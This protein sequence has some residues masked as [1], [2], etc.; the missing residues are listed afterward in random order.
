[1]T[2]RTGIIIHITEGHGTRA[3]HGLPMIHSFTV[4]SYLNMLNDISLVDKV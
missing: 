4:L 3:G 1:M 2:L